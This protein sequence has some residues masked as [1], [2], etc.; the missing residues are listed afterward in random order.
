M[1]RQIL[2]WRPLP[3][4]SSITSALTSNTPPSIHYLLL[5]TF[6]PANHWNHLITKRVRLYCTGRRS[7]NCLLN[8][9]APLF[10]SSDLLYWRR[11]TS[12]QNTFLAGDSIIHQQVVE[13]HG[14]APRR[15]RNY[16]YPGEGIDDITAASSEVSAEATNDPLSFL[17]KGTNDVCKTRSGGTAGS[18]P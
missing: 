6:F 10:F 8:Q 18:L 15:R 11:N 5:S 14:G 4:H 1:L 2:V 13:F 16:C 17:P 7:Y 9:L 12:L 3:L